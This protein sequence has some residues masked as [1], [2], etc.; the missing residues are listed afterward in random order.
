MRL[1]ASVTQGLAYGRTSPVVPVS[2]LLAVAQQ[3][4]DLAPAAASVLVCND[5]RDAGG[6]LDLCDAGPGGTAPCRRVP[7]RSGHPITVQLQ[8]ELPG[9]VHRGRPGIRGLAGAARSAWATGLAAQFTRNCCPGHGRLRGWRC[10]NGW[11]DRQ[12]RRNRRSPS[13][14]RNEVASPSRK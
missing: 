5:A 13:I 1:A 14:L 12:L 9:P 7:N 6:V 4:L 8:V 3:A 2:D 11:R 10:R